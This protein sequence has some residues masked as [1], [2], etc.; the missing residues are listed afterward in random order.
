MGLMD[1]IKDTVNSTISAIKPVT[2]SSDAEVNNNAV[3]S[4]EM[5]RL[6][7]QAAAEGAVLIK[8]DGTLPLKKGTVVSLFSRM[9]FDWFFVG[10]G[11]GGDGAVCDGAADVKNHYVKAN[12][13]TGIRNCEE[14]ELNEKLAEVYAK[15]VEKNPVT[16]GA[17]GAWSF[18]RKEM[19]LDV[20]TLQSVKGESDTAVVTI[21]RSAGED[22]DLVYENG[23]YLISD[24]ELELLDLAV[25]NFDKVVV[26]LNTSGI[27]D[28]SWMKKY[29]DKIGAV[30][31]VF[32]G[33]MESGNAVADLLCGKVNPCG[34][35]TDTIAKSYFDY[36]S[37]DN[38]GGRNFNNYTED[39]FVGYR[40]FESFD[41]NNVLYP[42]GYGLSYTDFSIEYIDTEAFDDGFEITAKITNT[43]EL[44]G[45][46]VAQLYAEKPVGKLGNP[47]RELV[48][49]AKTKELAPNESET[50]KMWVDAYQLTSFDDC[51]STNHA[52][53]YVA[54]E[55]EYSFYLGKNVREAEKVFSYFQEECEVYA[56][57]KQASAPQEHFEV[58]HAEIIDG[59]T[60]LRKKA[61][62]KR[63][64]DLGSRINNNLPED[65]EMTGDKGLKLSDVKDGKCTMEDFVAQLDMDE[66][67]AVTRGDYR[68]GSPLGTKGNAGVYG[69]VLESLRDKGIPPVTT[70]DGPTGIGLAAN[71][72]RVPIGTLLACTFDTELIEALHTE[73]AI[74]MKDRGSDVLLAPGLNIHRN[75]LCGRNFEY[76]SEDP[77]LTGKM[78][79]AAVR[80]IQSQGASACPKHFACNNQEMRR[81]KND[82]RVSER[83]LRE[84]YL[85]GFEICVKEA[86]PKN[87]MT[88][89]NR[90]NGVYG[91]YNYD[92]CTTILRGEWG[93]EGNVMTDWW[94]QSEKSPENPALKDQ[95]YR[96][97]AQVDLLMPG[98]AYH[99]DGK[100]D[101]T[102][103]T[104]LGKPFG[105]T[106]GEV[107]RC[108]MN[109]LDSVIKIKL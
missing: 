66:L 41:K 24:E 82:S 48:A 43:G 100:P 81:N 83:A 3:I 99:T 36:P 14:L 19:P 35:L 4:E 10:Y 18:N 101:G 57:H 94:M 15:W 31:Y 7:R 79:A 40:Y 39:I 70:S 84:I 22:R 23:S 25:D 74:E 21:G 67:E 34:R 12:L 62:A 75:P 77:Y 76:Y 56:Q 53:A 106:L 108:A 86:A 69:G 5:K 107:Q 17:W 88:S 91:H 95:A 50:V 90:I 72:S 92:L 60:V 63:K 11:S 42:F 68:M 103:W 54:E 51:G 47:A 85:K 105:I 61:V 46:E 37:S 30:M 16:E 73:L 97:R 93:Y 59:K 1:R 6:C 71:C 78:A 55:G 58:F 9:Q 44:A 52:G 26:L 49:F 27:I 80:G 89:Y 64:F 96:V 98:G 87:I 8:N 109:V 104:S 28:M 102:L 32:E 20:V 65:I 38:F 45:K 13:V 33:G 2:Q 29:G